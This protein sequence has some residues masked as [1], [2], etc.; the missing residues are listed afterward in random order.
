MINN[1]FIAVGG[2]LLS[3]ITSLATWILAR[4][5]YNSE[6]DN[7]L[8]INMQQSLDFYKKLSD[9][10]NKRLEEVLKRNSQLEMEVQDIKKQMFALMS[11]ICLDMTCQMRKQNYN[12]NIMEVTYNPDGSNNKP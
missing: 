12:P 8:I 5:K 4:K 1:L 9:D 3:S 10:T 6:V 7:T 11:S 2:L